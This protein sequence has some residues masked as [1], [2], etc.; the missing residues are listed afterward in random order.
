MLTAEVKTYEYSQIRNTTR[1]DIIS[2]ISEYRI[3]RI[4][5]VDK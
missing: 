4:W 2:T 5:L 3:K 1:W